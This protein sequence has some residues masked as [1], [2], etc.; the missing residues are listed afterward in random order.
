MKNTYPHSA[1]QCTEHLNGTVRYLVDSDCLATALLHNQSHRQCN[2][3]YSHISSCP[4][5]QRT[6]HMLMNV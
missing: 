2:C 1:G 6:L 4:G 5:D 3:L